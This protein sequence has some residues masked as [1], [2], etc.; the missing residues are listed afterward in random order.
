MNPRRS[1]VPKVDFGTLAKRYHGIE[2]EADPSVKKSNP[3]E[4]VPE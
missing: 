2:T 4:P 1:F 3:I